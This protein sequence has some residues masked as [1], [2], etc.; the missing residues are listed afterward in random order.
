[1]KAECY[2]Q[3]KYIFQSVIELP[4]SERA[5]FLDQNCAGDF[6]L[7]SKVESLIFSHEQVE[8]SIEAMAAEVAVT[9]LAEPQSRSLV[10]QQIMA[11]QI[12]NKIG[13]GGMGEVYLAQD[14]S[15]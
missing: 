10:G 1:M 6:Y 15:L 8:D 9:M 11:Y 14:T 7:R 2:Q 3:I 5:V 12:I 13:Q 4:D